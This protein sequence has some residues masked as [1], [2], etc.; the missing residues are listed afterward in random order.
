VFLDSLPPLPIA[1]TLAEVESFLAATT[2]A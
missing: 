1:R 2:D